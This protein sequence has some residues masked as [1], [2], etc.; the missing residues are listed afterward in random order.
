MVLAG[1]DLVTARE[2]AGH[3]DI[4]MTTKYAHATGDSKRRAVNLLLRSTP[5]DRRV[6]DG[7]FPQELEKRNS[8]NNMEA[9]PGFEPGN[10]GFADRRL[11]HLAM[12]PRRVKYVVQVIIRLPVN[13]HQS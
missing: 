13:P 11:S 9:A 5:S 3:A 7:H 1:A 12:P 10:N 4:A 2:I 8:L 6:A